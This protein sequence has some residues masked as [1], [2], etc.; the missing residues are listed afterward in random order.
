MRNIVAK[1]RGEVVTP[2]PNCPSSQTTGPPKHTAS[3]KR[4]HPKDIGH[5][6]KAE[7]ERDHE[8]YKGIKRHQ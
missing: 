8:G 5:A 2:I 6:G 7:H 4:R 1:S 3:F